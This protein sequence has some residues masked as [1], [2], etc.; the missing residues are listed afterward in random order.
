M[1]QFLK[2]GVLGAAAAIGLLVGCAADQTVGGT[3]TAG[4]APVVD[5]VALNGN[6]GEIDVSQPVQVQLTASGERAIRRVTI[7]VLAGTRRLGGLDTVL[8][9][10]VANVSITS[11]IALVAV[12]AGEQIELRATARDM[13]NLVG[14]DTTRVTTVANST[15]GGVDT[16]GNGGNT[17]SNSGPRVRIESPSDTAVIYARRTIPIRV[18]AVDTDGILRVDFTVKGAGF[19]DLAYTFRAATAPAPDSVTREQIIDIPATAV[20][21]SVI[22]IT[23]SAIDGLSTASIPV[24]KRFT[25]RTQPADSTAPIVNQRVSGRLEDSSTVVVRATDASPIRLLGYRLLDSV[26]NVI[27]TDSVLRAASARRTLDSQVFTVRFPASARGQLASVISFAEDT[28]AN[29]NRVN[30]GWSVP[31]NALF[32]AL[33][34]TD[35]TRSY[36]MLVYGR[37]LRMPAGSR[38]ADIAV[39]TTSGRFNVYVSNITRNRLDVFNYQTLTQ[40][41]SVAVGSEPWGMHLDAARG[42]LLVG[43]SGG[44]NISRV[45]LASRTEVGRF[46]TPNTRAWQVTET[47]DDKGKVTISATEFNYS[48][49]PQYV[50]RSASG[51][52]YYSTKPTSTAEPGTI[53][54]FVPGG[55]RNLQQL[56]Q[57]GDRPDANKFGVID[58]DEL[59]VIKG[60]GATKS[61]EIIM[62]DHRSTDTGPMT[63]SVRDSNTVRAASDLR[64]LGGDVVAPNLDVASLALT[65]T[66]FAAV[67]GDQRWIGFGEGNK[68]PAGRVMLFS[69]VFKPGNEV[70]A[71]PGVSV[72]D[73][74]NNASD[75][76][77]G[78]A[79]NRNSSSVAIQG[80]DAFFAGVDDNDFRF[81]LRL[82]GR[83]VT[84]GSGSGVA[85][86]PLN[87]GTQ[88]AT[89]PVTRATFVAGTEPVV[90][91]VDSYY[92]RLR[93]Q[94]P[95]RSKLY[96]P[97]RA[98]L[99]TAAEQAAGIAVKLFGLTEEGLVV[100]DVRTADIDNVPP[101]ALRATTRAK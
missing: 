30:R 3:A 4:I 41:A 81:Q 79:I 11:S 75:Q 74:T 5:V 97:L 13:R 26:G 17:G 25:V 100:I 92:Y 85:F 62:Y 15:G 21:D 19:T 43:N 12:N 77:F 65:D 93:G 90:D 49:R 69:D 42:D 78:L 64:A 31:D 40:Q 22:T 58:A 66:T 50:A 83:Y 24:T 27:S 44:T 87:D 99:P 67:G 61:D 73:L 88:S 32:P 96:G 9:T 16:T 101:A 23:A 82:Q 51:Y 86:H 20:L 47:V 45:D 52:V 28:V 33:S 54:R 8:A 59:V 80:T 1:T 94:L 95:I 57:Y 89:A 98:A 56:W 37:T 70:T 38:G 18:T 63:I 6:S 14:G 29:V 10:P 39:D 46:N 60:V 72:L 53:R 48:D 71:T 35:A 91:I 36:A 84:P 76:V 55:E 34:A 7:D 68:S 2:R